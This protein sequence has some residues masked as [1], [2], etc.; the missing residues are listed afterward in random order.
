MKNLERHEGMQ[1]SVYVP[2][3]GSAA[4][5][6]LLRNARVKEGF[7][8]LDLRFTETPQMAFQSRQDVGW[9][10]G[11]LIRIFQNKHLILV[12]SKKS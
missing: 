8:I 6:L 3:A 4:C 2:C 9:L 7:A 1:A 10:I 11:F 5:M 12:G